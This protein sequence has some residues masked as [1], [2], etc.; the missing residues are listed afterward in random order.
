MINWPNDLVTDVARRRC[1]IFIG[2]GISR[3][4]TNARGLSPKTWEDFLRFCASTLQNKRHILSLINK[5][6]LLTAC[7]IL[8]RTLGRDAFVQKLKDEFLTPQYHHAPIHETIFRLDSRIVATPNFDKIYE[9]Y[10]NHAANGSI[11]V[12]DNHHQ[13]LPDAIRSDGRL[14][15]KIHG[16]IDTPDRLVFTRSEYAEARWRFRDFYR[17]LEALTMTHTFLFLGCGL[18]DPDLRLL[19][20]DIFFRHPYSRKHVMVLPRRVLHPD[21]RSIVEDTMSL[22]ILDYSPANQHEELVKSLDNLSLLVEQQRLDLKKS[23]N[24]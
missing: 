19:M 15:L 7:D 16:S 9:T 13:D 4:C 18:N 24:W 20:E 8:K 14:I 5:G 23:G 1:V 17:V 11:I 12:K 2:A 22:R 6:D 10:A 3:N 21:V